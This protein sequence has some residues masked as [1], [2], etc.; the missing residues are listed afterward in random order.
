[1]SAGSIV[2]FGLVPIGR[3]SS[4]SVPVVPASV[5]ATWC[6]PVGRTVA[7][8]PIGGIICEALPALRSKRRPCV[9]PACVVRNM[10]ADVPLP[11][12]KIRAHV[13]WAVSTFTHAAT[14][15]SCRPAA[16]PC[17]SST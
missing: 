14:V 5:T 3:P 16:M 6:Q 17:G 2:M 13:C 12:S 15:K 11:K 1:M 10:N 7:G 4:H 9:S 8:S